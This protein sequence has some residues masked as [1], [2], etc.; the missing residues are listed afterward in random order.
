MC[1]PQYALH[2]EDMPPHCTDYAE[3]ARRLRRHV[4]NYDKS[5][6]DYRAYSAGVDAAVGRAA[7][8]DADRVDLSTPFSQMG[9]LV[10]RIAGS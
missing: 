10:R 6:L 2:L 4:P 9:S 7:F 1:R 3:A 8:T 5:R